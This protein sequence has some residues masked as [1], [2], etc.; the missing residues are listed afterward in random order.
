MFS[1]G[2]LFGA[3]RGISISDSVLITVTLQGQG[4]AKGSSEG[5]VVKQIQ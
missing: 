2:G 5:G 3:G 4:A 1:R